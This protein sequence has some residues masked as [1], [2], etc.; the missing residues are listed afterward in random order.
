MP[1]VECT[2]N[3]RWLSIIA[4]VHSKWIMCRC[5]PP[6][7]DGYESMCALASINSLISSQS[8]G[9]RAF[10][11]FIIVYSAF[12]V[13]H[14]SIRA[15]DGIAAM[16]RK[17][18]RIKHV[19][20]VYE[21]AFDELFFW[22]YLCDLCVSVTNVRGIQLM[23]NSLKTLIAEYFRFSSGVLLLNFGFKMHLQYAV[24][25][26]LPTQDQRLL[27]HM[28][29]HLF[30]S[31]NVVAAVDTHKSHRSRSRSRWWLKIHE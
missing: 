18:G 19:R 9:G 6:V 2:L 7:S 15:G 8:F 25:Y 5:W 27:Q 20:R 21:C 26:S 16:E 14:S 31:L 22:K 10:S 23:A 1:R 12:K 29:V 11:K 28:Q 17:T 13:K 24:E 4:C 30:C 3:D